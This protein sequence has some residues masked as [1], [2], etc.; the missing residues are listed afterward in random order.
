MLDDAVGDMARRC[1]L[2]S[3][4][5]SDQPTYPHGLQNVL[6][7]NDEATL[8]A[9]GHSWSDDFDHARTHPYDLQFV[10]FLCSIVATRDAMV[11]SLAQRHVEVVAIGGAVEEG[12]ARATA[13]EA[14]PTRDVWRTAEF[15]E[16]SIS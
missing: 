9:A 1:V 16:S 8:D 13:H 5:E 14:V 11:R 15:L 2:S 3:S 4:N 12:V 6:L 10:V 7:C